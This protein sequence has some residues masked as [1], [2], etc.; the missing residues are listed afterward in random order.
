MKKT[1]KYVMLVSCLAHGFASAG[2]SKPNV[3]FFLIDD[4]GWKD[5]GCYGSEFYESPR[6][7]SLAKSGVRFTDAYA[8]CPV[9]TPSR[10]SI[11]SGKYP[12]TSGATNLG[13]IMDP[14]ELTLAEAMKEEGYSTFF[15]GKWHLG[16]TPDTLPLGQGFDVNIGGAGNG[17]PG[18]YYY[19][20]NQN[21]RS[22]VQG[23]EKG[24]KLG[25]YLTD[26][27]GNEAVKLIET[28]D[29]NKP[30]YMHF[31]FY[32]VHTPIQ[33]KKSLLEHFQKR[34]KKFNFKG[35][36]LKKCGTKMLKQHQ[37]SP[38]FAS[39][40]KSVDENVG[41][42]ID[43][44]NAENLLENTIIIVGSD[45][46]GASYYKNA[47]CNLPLRGA[48]GW[49]HE[50]GIRVPLVVYWKGTLRS[51]VS[52]KPVSGPD[53]YPTVLELAGIEKKPQQHVDG[54]SFVRA[55]NGK[56]DWKK[57]AI[58]WHF[59]HG[60]ASG[61]QPGSAIRLGKYKLI[62]PKKGGI[63]LYDL[64]EDLSETNNLAQTKPEVADDLKKK[65]Q[66][67]LST[68]PQNQTKP[69]KRKKRSSLK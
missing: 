5:L 62:I 12:A 67:W 31:C 47:T 8:A 21:P 55:L 56:D 48:K 22:A 7:D 45:N 40:V 13:N 42:V 35:P 52:A 30:F 64:S 36:A 49:L 69:K 17:Q 18:G 66:S 3:V 54:E 1:L 58:Y 20:Y 38:D 61:S 2:L 15:L 39:M 9:C 53:F 4:M 10:H 37:D 59:P 51:G 23:L 6:I 57:R 44:L 28:R 34:L 41:K 43:C 68:R 24:G 14:S 32:S 11:L 27:L 60:H 29:K 63:E 33:P 46:G 16:H 65:L 19:P 26:R 50:A 25:E